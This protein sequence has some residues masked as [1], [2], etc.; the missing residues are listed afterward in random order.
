M[1]V[2]WL[3]DALG[4]VVASSI[5]P[6]PPAADWSGRPFFAPLRDG[7]DSVLMPL[8]WGMLT[9]NWFLSY[10]AAIRDDTGRFLG[11]VQASLFT[12]DVGRAYAELD[13]PQGARAGVFRAGDGAPMVL[14]P[15]P[16]PGAAGLRLR[17]LLAEDGA[18][19]KPL[20]LPSAS[21]C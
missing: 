6:N 5:S 11:L 12:T 7:A 4:A 17:L 9:C 13:L 2:L 1:T 20:C 16:P 3:A 19:A 18:G 8:T 14:W 15:P 10:S 21:W